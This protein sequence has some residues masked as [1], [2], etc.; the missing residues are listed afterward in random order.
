MIL[1]IILILSSVSVIASIIN[2]FDKRSNKQESSISMI[3]KMP[4][5]LPIITLVSNNKA[6][7]FLLDSGSNISH[8]C[9]EYA[10]DLESNII[11]TYKE[12]TVEGLGATNTGITMCIAKLED[13]RGNLYD[14]KL[15]ISSELSSVANT[16]EQSAGVKI[17]GL[18]GTDFLRNYDYI[19]D[20]KTLEVYTKR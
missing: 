9:S 3:K 2:L 18:L 12:A 1:N 17:H 13:I 15:S 8:I 10:S 14:V 4:G 5:N 16:I 20:F 7:N 6:F 11:G 19:M